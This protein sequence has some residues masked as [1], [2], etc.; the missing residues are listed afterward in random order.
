MTLA[1][2]GCQPAKG[3][4]KTRT[5]LPIPVVCREAPNSTRFLLRSSV[6]PAADGRRH[7][8]GPLADGLTIQ[9]CSS[10][11][12]RHDRRLRNADDWGKC[13]VPPTAPDPPPQPP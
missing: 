4:L 11:T 6:T 13:N 3:A 9:S 1:G 5:V 10:S 8:L 12:P 7:P 2:M